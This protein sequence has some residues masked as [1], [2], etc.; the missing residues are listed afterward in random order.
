M[1]EL[2]LTRND[3][4]VLWLYTVLTPVYILVR[5]DELSCVTLIT[6][7]SRC[8]TRSDNDAGWWQ[9]IA[10]RIR[11][12]LD[13][14][15][16]GISTWRYPFRFIVRTIH[17]NKLVRKGDRNIR[18][19]VVSRF[20][21][22]ELWCRIWYSNQLPVNTL[23]L[24]LWDDFFDETYSCTWESRRRGHFN[25]TKILNRAQ[26]LTLRWFPDYFILGSQ[27]FA[28]IR[29]STFFCW[30]VHQQKWNE[31]F[32][33]HLYHHDERIPLPFFRQS[34]SSFVRTYDNNETEESETNEETWEGGKRI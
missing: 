26:L 17:S 21:D 29:C 13:Q 15:F 23:H 2:D 4:T 12:I 28:R 25:S 20:R 1:I 18:D 19:R 11:I 16:L 22:T 8:V 10:L 32:G 6:P 33:G 24:G 34:L 14:R 30:T 31:F 5:S 7:D 3:W 27:G 9:S